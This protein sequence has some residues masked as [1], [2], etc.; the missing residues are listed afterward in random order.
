MTTTRGNRLTN[1]TLMKP[2]MPSPTVTIHWGD[3]LSHR[4]K[5]GQDWLQAAREA[6]VT[7]PTGCL[8]GSCGACEIEVNDTVIRACIATVPAASSG[9]LMVQIASE[10]AW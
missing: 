6:G 2:T 1:P 10:P 4:T 7:I 3:G 9:D 5:V 8:N